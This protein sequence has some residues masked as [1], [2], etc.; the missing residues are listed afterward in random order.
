ML[1]Y[2]RSL[3]KIRIQYFLPLLVF[4]SLCSLQIPFASAATVTVAWDQNPETDVIGYKFYYGTDSKNYQ[5]TEGVDVENNTSCTVSGLDEGTT[6]HFAVKAY[7]NKNLESDYSEELVYTIPTTPPPTPP[8]HQYELSVATNGNGSVK[9]TPSGGTY[10]EGTEVQLTATA[11]TGWEFSD[12]SGDLS[13]SGNPATITMDADINVTATFTESPITQHTLDVTTVGKGWV[14]IEPDQAEYDLGQLVTMTATADPGWIF[15]GWNG[16]LSGISNPTTLTVTGDHRVTATFADGTQAYAE[17]FEAYNDGDDPANWMDTAAN[18]SMAENGTLF[19]IFDLSGDKVFGTTSTQ[20]NIHSHYTGSGIDT[21]SAYEYSGRL[22]MTSSSGDIGVTFFSQYPN[23]DAYYRLRQ[24]GNSAFHIA[25][26]PHGTEINGDSVTGVVPSANVWYWF[27]VLVEDTG[28]RTE[29]RAKVWPENSVEPA[30]WQLD[31]YDNS[32]SR[33]RAGTIGVW[34]MGSGSK[35]WDNLTVTPLGPPPLRYTMTVDTVGNG[36]VVLDPPGGTYD[37]GA[38]VQLTAIAGPGSAFDKWSDD[39][40]GFANPITITMEEDITVT[41]YFEATV[42]P[43]FT[44]TTNIVGNGSVDLDPLGGTYDEGTVVQLTAVANRGSTF[45]SWSEDITGTVNP[46][47]IT[48]NG[49]KAVTANFE[50]TV[51]PQFT[52]TVDTIGEGSVELHPSSG[53]YEKGTLVELRAVAGPGSSFDRWSGDITGSDNPVTITMDD[54]KDVTAA[55]NESA[56]IYS[57]TFDAYSVGSDPADWLDTA[58][59]NSMSENDSLFKIFGL[60][61]DKVF[62]TT[63]TQTNIHSHHTGPGIDALSAYEYSGRM[64]MTASRGGIG[65]T[66]FSQYPNTDAYYRL[67]RYGNSTF[68]IAPHPHGTKIYGDH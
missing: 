19:E 6:Y 24:Y 2:L 44:L 36:S 65:V 5:P 51:V 62:G 58:A 25:P 22:M 17:D 56:Y 38:V 52:L 10:D 35:Y 57:E 39:I 13:G 21:L 64:M 4:F 46:V 33:L 49:D 16:D 34:S 66:F 20:T 48:M 68:H 14:S 23:T 28:S 37:E 67:R 8:P 47:T 63:S 60:S 55:F 43:Q 1:S 11:A 27:R 61:G 29:I 59:K 7:N 42:V 50:E 32:A 40:T 26:H 41:A 9:L 18:N 3:K 15:T 54:D 30:V 12:W 45:D 53:T 31:C